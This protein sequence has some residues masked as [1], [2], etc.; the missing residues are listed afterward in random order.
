MHKCDVCG[1]EKPDVT[2]QIDPYAYEINDEE[3]WC[4]LCEACAQELAD[5]I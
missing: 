5:D 2:W 1:Q 3:I 4:W